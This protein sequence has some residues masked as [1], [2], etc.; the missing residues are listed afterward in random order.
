MK[1]RRWIVLT[2]LAALLLGVPAFSAQATNLAGTQ[3]RKVG[4][5]K[6][7]GKTSFKC[8]KKASKLV[9]LLVP[10]K[11]IS[12]T[13]N[14]N[15]V[16]DEKVPNLMPVFSLSQTEVRLAVK[17][18]FPSALKARDQNISKVAILITRGGSLLTDWA[19]YDTN[20]PNV[21][22]I[23][24]DF[25]FN[26]QPY[27]G[28]GELLIVKVIHMNSFGLGASVTQSIKM[29]KFA[30]ESA[31]NPAK[32]ATQSITTKSIKAIWS[33]SQNGNRIE[34]QPRGF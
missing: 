20:F 2:L 9:W 26:I 33:T 3:C 16:V 4:E 1:P 6:T 22:G 10:G 27:Y 21:E 32:P 13:A 28:E 24:K 23:S 29:A 30:P 11:A 14:Q 31:A 15:D 34:P 19:Q 12:P 5:F 17:V 18:I 25:F 8:T 7:S